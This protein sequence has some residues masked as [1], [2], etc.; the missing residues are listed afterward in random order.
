MTTIPERETILKP[1]RPAPLSL[2]RSVRV[3]E[4]EQRFSRGRLRTVT[5]EA[6]RR[7]S[8]IRSWRAPETAVSQISEQQPD[9]APTRLGTKGAARPVAGDFAAGTRLSE[10]ERTARM[11]AVEQAWKEERARLTEREAEEQRR[12]LHSRRSG[13]FALL[14]DLRVGDRVECYTVEEVARSLPAA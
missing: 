7:S 9:R 6:K 13:A 4:V 3:G 12:A 8:A 10:A 14:S 1:T 5:V 11:R 2:K